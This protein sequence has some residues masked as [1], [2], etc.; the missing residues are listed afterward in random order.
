MKWDGLILQCMLPSPNKSTISVSECLQSWSEGVKTPASVDNQFKTAVIATVRWSS[1]THYDRCCIK[2][3][4]TCTNNEC[5]PVIT[6]CIQILESHGIRLRSCKVMEN[7]PNGCYF[8]D[9][10]YSFLAFKCHYLNSSILQ[11]NLVF[12]LF[13]IVVWNMSSLHWKDD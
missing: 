8:F 7:K 12:R 10:L 3:T 5:T 1:S 11:D 9:H 13:T 6:G 2:P 4:V